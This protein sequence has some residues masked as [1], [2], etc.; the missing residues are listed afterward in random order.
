MCDFSHK[1]ISRRAL[2]RNSARPGRTTGPGVV[3]ESFDAAGRA[4]RALVVGWDAADWKVINP[5]LDRGQ[6]PALARF[7]EDGVMADLTTLEPVLSPMLWNSIATGKRADAHGVLGF[8]EVNPASGSVRPVTSTSRTAKALWN[9]LSQEGLRTNVVGWFGSH[10]AEPINGVCVSDAYTRAL[11]PGTVYPERLDETLR[12]LRVEPTEIDGDIAR[13]FVPQAARIDPNRPNLLPVLRKILSECFSTHAAA[14]HI[15]EHEPW[16][17]MAVYYIGIDH[18]SHAFMNFHPPKPDWIAEDQFE[19]YRDVV[20]GGYRLMDLF[21]ARLLELAGPDTSVI[22]LSD[23]GFHSDH[24]RPR[25]IPGI[26]AGPCEQHRKLGILAMKGD[27][28]RRDERIY[29]VNLLDIAPTVLAMYGLPAGEDMPGRVLTEAFE[30]APDLARIPSWE[31]VE[32]ESGMHTADAEISDEDADLLTAQF[33]A[34][35]YIND[36]VADRARA[37]AECNRERQWNLA[38]VYMSSWRFAEAL[39]LLEAICEE[40]PER[41]DFALS[42]ADC[43]RRLGMLEEAAATAERAVADNAETPGG[44]FVLGNIAFERGDTSGALEH[45]SAAERAG[46]G[47]PELPVRVGFAYLK[48]RRWDDARRAFENALEID[49]QSPL[50]HHGLGLAHLRQRHREAAAH[51]LLTSIGYR[52]DSPQPHYWL[53]VC[54]SQ[55]GRKERAIQAFQTALSFHPPLRAA[56]RWLAALCAD[57]DEA[58]YHR[59]AARDALQQVRERLSRLEDTRQQA[60][61][62]AIDRADAR[63]ARLADRDAVSAPAATAYEGGLVLNIVSGLPRSGTSMMMQ[64]LSAAGVTVMTD[65]ERGPDTDNPEGYFEWEE[66]RNVGQ[67]PGILR[68]AEGRTVKVVSMLLP[69]LPANNRYRV[70]FMDRP[71]AEVAASQS[72]MLENRGAAGTDPERVTRALSSHRERILNGLKLSANFEVLIVDYPGLVREPKQWV[73]RIA[74]FLG[75]VP[76]ASRMYG[77][78]RPELYRNRKE[79]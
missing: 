58:A 6:L 45:F 22:L 25:H 35:G 51:S 41:G 39:P 53:G 19:L 72:R 43:Q 17:F 23:H 68:K 55:L 13:L 38:R 8:T 75:C 52:H 46:S 49:P 2:S 42:L 76:E 57:P 15:M 30:F 14:T 5:L 71:V 40:A 9:I 24:L 34:L 29:G 11:L 44:R 77:A 54:L 61:H 12:E 1:I 37:A 56:H 60:R 65:A 26:P 59:G 69:A 62:R 33:V 28:I 70:I 18:F 20:S 47:I 3:A 7:L 10:P 78:I 50:A 27:G 74:E 4:A 63:R 16:D 64:M 73:P 21:L 67:D 36:P 48:L 32:G 31:Q 79:V 66:I